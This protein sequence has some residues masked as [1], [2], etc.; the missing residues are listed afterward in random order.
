M[1]KIVIHAVQQPKGTTVEID[2]FKIPKLVNVSF[3]HRV[4]D[5]PKVIM[6][7]YPEEV[8]IEGDAE[9]LTIAF[10]ASCKEK[11][12]ESRSAYDETVKNLDANVIEGDWRE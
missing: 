8:V 2:G 1:S 6:E 3:E 4:G 11:M 5:I 9:Y 7:V 12:S 10:C